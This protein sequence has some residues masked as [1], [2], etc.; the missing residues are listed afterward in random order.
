MGEGKRL[1]RAPDRGCAWSA[2]PRSRVLW[3]G[4]LLGLVATVG[5]LRVVR[6]MYRSEV[7]LFYRPSPGPA[8]WRRPEAIPG[9]ARGAPEEMASHP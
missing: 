7:V 4:L 8:S 2:S 1:A 9:P 5:I 3:L 6:P